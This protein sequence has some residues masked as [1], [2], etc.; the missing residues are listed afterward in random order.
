MSTVF[1]ISHRIASLS[2][3][4][5]PRL[6]LLVAPGSK[7]AAVISVLLGS[8]TSNLRASPYKQVTVETLSSKFSGILHCSQMFTGRV[9]LW[10]EVRICG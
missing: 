1:D 9:V 5:Y 4:S 2:V 3:Y 7:A 8:V 6:P 10:N